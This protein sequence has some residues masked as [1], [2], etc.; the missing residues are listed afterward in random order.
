[1]KFTIDTKFN[2]GDTIY[3]ADHYYDYYA[4]HMPYTITDIVVNIN[5]RDIRTMYYVAQGEHTECLPEN[6][7]FGT[8]TECAKW[9]EEHN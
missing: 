7:C 1:M 2:I 4:S 5:N 6:W 9:C 8:Y 3:V